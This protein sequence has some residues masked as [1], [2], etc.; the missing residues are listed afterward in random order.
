MPN[1]VLPPLYTLIY[2]GKNKFFPMTKGDHLKL[3]RDATMVCSTAQGWGSSFVAIA[4]P[5]VGNVVLTLQSTGTRHMSTVIGYFDPSHCYDDQCFT[6]CTG[7]YPHQFR[8]IQFYSYGALRRISPDR[9]YVYNTIEL[10]FTKETVSFLSR[11][12]NC[13]FQHT[14]DR[15]K[16]F[17]FGIVVYSE[18]VSWS[19]Q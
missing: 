13:T 17:V 5:P 8:G 19:I 3:S 2:E 1:P 15:I 4:H 10:V 7:V 16:D 9:L 14:I 18:G 12:P 11:I 6:N